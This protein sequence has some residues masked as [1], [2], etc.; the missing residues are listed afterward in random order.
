MDN[1]APSNAALSL[2]SCSVFTRSRK[3]AAHGSVA[4]EKKTAAAGRGSGTV[5]SAFYSQNTVNQTVSSSCGGSSGNR[6]GAGGTFSDGELFS[7]YLTVA[8]GAGVLHQPKDMSRVRLSGLELLVSAAEGADAAMRCAAA[9]ANAAESA[10][11]YAAGAAHFAHT[12]RNA[13]PA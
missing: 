2:A 11:L 6:L 8:A 12:T 7:T 3:T 4:G 13:T 1:N 9:A 10:A 5:N